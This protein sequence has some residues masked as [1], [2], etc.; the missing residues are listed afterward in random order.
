MQVFL[1][2]RQHCQK[3]K[4]RNPNL[5]NPIPTG[6]GHFWPQQPKAVWHIRSFMTGV[7]KIHDFVYF[8]I[9]LVPMK[10]FL[11]KEL[12]NFEKLKKKILPFRHQRVP[13][14][15][16][17]SKNLKIWGFFPKNHTFST[18]IWILHVLSFLLRYITSVL[19]K[20]FKFS[21]F[22]AMK[23]PLITTFNLWPLAAE[24]VI[25]EDYIGYLWTAKYLNNYLRSSFGHFEVFWQL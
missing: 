11:K 10:L 22:F 25:K 13:P 20:I 9:C 7:T 24:I 2:G 6:G 5:L 1:K 8:S 23:F 18:W 16:K 14:L 4:F 21:F 15:E 17:K 19:L 12:W 3:L